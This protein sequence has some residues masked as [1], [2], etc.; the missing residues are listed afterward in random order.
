MSI[1]PKQEYSLNPVMKS[2]MPE[3]T[4]IHQIGLYNNLNKCMRNSKNPGISKID[5]LPTSP[6]SRS[7]IL[8]ETCNKNPMKDSYNVQNIYKV[9]Y[10]S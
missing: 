10:E 2:S 4:Y 6:N 3:K 9:F 1:S 8:K 7:P 5:I